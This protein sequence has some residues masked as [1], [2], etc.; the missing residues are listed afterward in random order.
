MLE[1]IRNAFEILKQGGIIPVIQ[2]TPSGES[3]VMPRMRRP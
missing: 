2:L 3:D 1:D